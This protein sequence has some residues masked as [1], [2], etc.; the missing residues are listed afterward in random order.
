MK[1]TALSLFVI[2]TLAGLLA[3][4]AFAQSGGGTVTATPASQTPGGSTFNVDLTL[5]FTNPPLTQLVSYDAI[6]EGTATQNG[7]SISQFAVTGYTAPSARPD[8]QRI[9]TG[10][11]AFGSITT[12]HAGFLQTGDEAASGTGSTTSPQTNFDLGTFTFSIGAVNPGTYT[13][14]TTLLATSASNFSDSNN[15]SG[16]LAWDNAATFQITVPATVPEPA[17]WS[18]MALGGLGSFGATLLR[19]RRKS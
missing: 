2:F 15:G 3:Q 6:F 1:K 5:T 17:T 14:H 9:A 10:S 8:F 4:S 19:A 13:F 18:L 11:D 7:S 16:I 12:D